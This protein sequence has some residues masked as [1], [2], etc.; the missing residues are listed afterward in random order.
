MS[1][2]KTGSFPWENDGWRDDFNEALNGVNR[3]VGVLAKTHFVQGFREGG[4]KT[5]FGKWKPSRKEAGATLV[6]TGALRRSVNVIEQSKTSDSA[7]FVVG[8]KGVGYADKHNFGQG[9]TKREFIGKSTALEAKMLVALK[10]L[11]NFIVS[12]K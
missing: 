3:I 8:S 4:G 6:K 7:S 10:K 2:K 12:K 5:D 11:F 9:V 1:V